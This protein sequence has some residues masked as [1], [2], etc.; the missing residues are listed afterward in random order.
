[1][2]DFVP[3]ND[4][5]LLP[6][7]V[8]AHHEAGHAVAALA[9]GVNFD[10]V[11]I[12]SDPELGISGGVIREV[13]DNPRRNVIVAMAGP[14]AGR[15]ELE[16]LIERVPG[17]RL[18]LVGDYHD[19]CDQDDIDAELA[20]VDDQQRAAWTAEA[21]ALVGTQVEAIACIATLLVTS[22]EVSYLQAKAAFEAAQTVAEVSGV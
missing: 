19:A 14:E 1:M 12:T 9:L 6:S 18:E 2:P 10:Q 20:C 4:G 11:T 8:I 5:T 7:E 22:R 21:V 13:D 15:L 16:R 17:R 3:H